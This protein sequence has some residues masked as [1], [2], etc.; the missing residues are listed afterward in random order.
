[1]KFIYGNK[2]DFIDTH[3]AV[4]LSVSETQKLI[5]EVTEDMMEI[6]GQSVINIEVAYSFRETG[7]TMVFGLAFDED[8]DNIYDEFSIYVCKDYDEAMAYLDENND[9][10]K[11]D[12]TFEER[13][14]ERIAELERY[15]KDELINMIIEEHKDSYPS[16]NPHKEI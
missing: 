10:R 12:W 3:D 13:K 5:D 7:D 2:E 16:Y 8:R 1:M 15:T 11:I 4:R 6:I 14:S 9:L